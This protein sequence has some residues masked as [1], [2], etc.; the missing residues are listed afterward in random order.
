VDRWVEGF[1]YDYGVYP[2]HTFVEEHQ[3]FGKHLEERVKA[4]LALKQAEWKDKCS[5]TVEVSNIV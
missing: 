4:Q 5:K 3:T 2:D 1:M